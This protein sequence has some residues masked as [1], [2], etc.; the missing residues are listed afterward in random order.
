[1]EPTLNNL[2]IDKL[3]EDATELFVSVYPDDWILGCMDELFYVGII[4]TRFDG[5]CFVLNIIM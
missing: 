4:D 5:V 2:I 1:M 3:N